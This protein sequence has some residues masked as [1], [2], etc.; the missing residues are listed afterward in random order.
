MM[1]ETKT[2]TYFYNDESYNF[3]F[4]TNLSTSD[5]AIF[6][7]TVVDTIIDDANYDSVLRDVIFDYTVIN[8]FTDID[9]SLLKEVNE[10]GGIITNI[11]LLEEF[12]LETNI[13]DIIKANTFPALFDELNNA[14]DKSI[15]YRTGIHLS[16]LSDAIASLLSTLEKKIDGIDTDGMMG[17]AKKFA[18]MADEL[19]ADSIV[20]SYMKSGEHMRN[21]AEIAKAKA[22]KEEI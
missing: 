13:V 21:L 2:G 10:Y 5:K 3:S 15:E 6:V 20:D 14:V 16:P 4:V 12:L 8:M 22:E 17:M 19:N 9:T 1:N 7:R 11:D 18:E